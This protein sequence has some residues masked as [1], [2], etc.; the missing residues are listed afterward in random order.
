MRKGG[1]KPIGKSGLHKAVSVSRRVA[2]ALIAK[3]FPRHVCFEL[4]AHAF[5]YSAVSRVVEPG[6][7][8]LSA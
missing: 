7:A 5:Q 4:L 3:S 1:G 8:S 6:D 2:A